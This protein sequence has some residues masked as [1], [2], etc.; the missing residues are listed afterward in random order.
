VDGEGFAED[1][2]SRI[3]GLLAGSNSA[4]GAGRPE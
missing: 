1:V 3:A 2:Y 4:F